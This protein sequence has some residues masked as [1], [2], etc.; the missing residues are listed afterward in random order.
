MRYKAMR[1]EAEAHDRLH[2]SPLDGLFQS[3]ERLHAGSAGGYGC[4]SGACDTKFH[5][6]DASG[7]KAGCTAVTSEIDNKRA[8]EILAFPDFTAARQERQ[9]DCQTCSFRKI[10]SS[11]CLASMMDDGSGECSGGQRLFRLASDLLE[12]QS[13]P[14][15]VQQEQTDKEMAIT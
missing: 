11:G 10:C 5:T 6:I 8:T 12:Q 13:S 2:V 4:W 3:V 9:W 15:A 1:H 14:H 7:Y